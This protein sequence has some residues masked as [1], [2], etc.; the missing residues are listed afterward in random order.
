MPLPILH[1]AQQAT[2]ADLL[3]L[4]LQTELHWSGQLATETALDVGTALAN[5]ELAGLSEGNRLLSAALPAEMSPQQA[6]AQV[7][8]HFAAAGA[9]CLSWT[10]NPSRRRRAGR[11]R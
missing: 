11:W 5:G 9:A 2:P 10:M 1:A 8:G 7:Q 3:R 4:F 6:V